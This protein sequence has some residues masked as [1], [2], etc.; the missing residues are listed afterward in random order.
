M[1]E[2]QNKP[3]ANP[4]SAPERN[5]G[6]VILSSAVEAFSSAIV[7]WALGSIAIGMAGMFAGEMI[8]SLPPGFDGRQAAEADHAGHQPSWRLPGHMPSLGL[9]GH[10]SAL[11]CFFA[12]FFVHSLW[13]GFHGKAVGRKGRVLSKLREDWFGLI[14]G[15]AISAWVAAVILNMVPNFSLVQIL[16]QSMVLPCIREATHALFG[17]S[18]PAGLGSWYSWYEANNEKLYFW[19]IYLAGVFD[20]LGVPNFKTLARWAWR[21]WQKRKQMPLPASAGRGDV[22]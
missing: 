3:D 15:N 14:V 12:I 22:A 1:A 7:V 4:Q 9:G 16:W 13:M 6:E 11:V 2:T 20:D 19:L 17:G 8:P 10:E 18:M 21:R 5:A